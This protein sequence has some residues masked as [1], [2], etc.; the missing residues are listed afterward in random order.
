[1]SASDLTAIADRGYVKSEK[2]LASEAASV[3][4]LAPK[5]LT[6]GAKA[7]GRF[8]KQDFVL[9]SGRRRLPVSR[10]RR[11]VSKT[12]Y[13]ISSALCGQDRT[14]GCALDRKA[15]SVREKVLSLGLRLDSRSRPTNRAYRLSLPHRRAWRESPATRR[16]LER[17]RS[18]IPR[19]CVSSSIAPPT[20]GR[21]LS[22]PARGPQ[23]MTLLFAA[24]RH[25][26]AMPLRISA[27]AGRGADHLATSAR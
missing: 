27:P 19:P 14:R 11:G 8:G 17:A 7:D 15:K 24:S 18:Q 13:V 21:C 23:R 16:R 20:C 3:T 10:W 4:P 9:R 25:A 12:S 2:I 26:P 6:S 22:K 5:P 1:M